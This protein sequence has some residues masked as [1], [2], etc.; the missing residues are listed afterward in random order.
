MRGVFV[1]F[2]KELVDGLRD[3]RSLFSLLLFPLLGPVLIA[4]MLSQT[5]ERLAD[6]STARLPVAGRANAPALVAFL[7][8]RG[9][10]V[11][12]PPADVFGAV[13]ERE[14]PTVLIIPDDYGARFRTGKPAPVQLVV[15]DSRADAMPT[16]RR[17]E[18]LIE[19]YGRSVG[20]LRLLA[21]GTNPELAEPVKLERVDLSTPKKRAA[22]FLNVIPM[23]VLI[24]SF[25]GG[26]Y[27]ATDATAGERERGSL[28][29]LLI[30]PIS[31][32]ALVMGKWLTALAFSGC[33][34]VFTLAVT[35]G[36]L[37]YV[38]LEG[39]GV[40]V[41]VTAADVAAILGL[42]LPLAVF[43]ASAQLFVA[44]FARTHKEAQTYL[45]LMLFL[46]MLPGVFA[47]VTPIKT[48]LFMTAIPVI[49]QQQL[50]SDIIRGDVVEPLGFVFSA[51]S[52]LVLG[53]ACMY[54]TAFLF[55]RES[56]IYGR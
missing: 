33:N 38:S 48:Q 21:H 4:V 8:E 2:G 30:T 26:M 42:V 41:S 25:I 18:A 1:V 50:L 35:L 17:V 28:E 32:P 12:A 31:R 36:T 49:G 56:I 5:A 19:G 44:S 47:T 11:V 15:D 51:L 52:S 16:V 22:L 10:E 34:V 23:F 55:R 6:A 37:H 27:T 46:P 20:T 7:E 40:S 43:V 3:R 14:V 45:S 39:L 53:L 9:V 54:G 13:R 29:P 24:A